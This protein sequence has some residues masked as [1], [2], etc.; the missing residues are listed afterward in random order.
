[1]SR[2]TAGSVTLAGPGGVARPRVG[3]E[4]GGGGAVQH[5]DL[6]AHGAGEVPLVAARHR[7][8]G[9]ELDAVRV[10]RAAAHVELVVEVRPRGE[11]GGADVADEV[12]L[13]HPG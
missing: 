9:D 10:D 7:V 6:R 11:S 4:D 5:G 12:A 3:E 8:A 2:P 13:L 1:I